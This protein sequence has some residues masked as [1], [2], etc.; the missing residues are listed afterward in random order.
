MQTGSS[1]ALQ[2]SIFY[3]DISAD[4]GSGAGYT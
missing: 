3:P 1:A 2:K 4:K